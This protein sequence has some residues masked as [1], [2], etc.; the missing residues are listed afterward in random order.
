ME[1][2]VGQEAILLGT[3]AKC[4][5]DPIFVIDKDGKYIEII[6][7]VVRDLYDSAAYLRE[8]TLFDVLP[9]HIAERFMSTVE[10]AIGEKQLQVIEYQLHSS[11]MR[12][13]PMDGPNEA[14]W[15]EGRVAPLSLSPE[16][17]EHVIW[18]AINITEKKK[19][20]LSCDRMNRDL[21]KALA[22]ID[23]LHGI[24]PI[25]SHCKKIRDEN[26]NW[27]Q[28]EEYIQ[29]HSDAEFSHGICPDCVELLYPDLE[30]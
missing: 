28:L 22:E 27:K 5:P 20:Q 6:G 29:A 10:K 18:M 7:G 19:A 24:L 23:R 25:C 12:S 8:K 26:G 1:Y 16:K 14:Q 11:I 3:V 13:N 4:I 17:T 15:Y 9:V 2:V 21:K 30:R